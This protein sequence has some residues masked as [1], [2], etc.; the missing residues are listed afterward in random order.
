MVLGS[1]AGL[2]LVSVGVRTWW[3]PGILSRSFLLRVLASGPLGSA[4]VLMPQDRPDLPP[5]NFRIILRERSIP[6]D[7]PTPIGPG[8]SAKSSIH[9]AAFSKGGRSSFYS[10]G[11]VTSPAYSRVLGLPSRGAA[12]KKVRWVAASGRSWKLA[13]QRMCGGRVGS[14]GCARG[15]FWLAG[16]FENSLAQ[17]N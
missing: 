2:S 10:A 16:E 7:S 14:L 6:P 3:G 11:L 1:R 4:P 12:A 15:R 5:A 17:E 8:L 9:T 13:M